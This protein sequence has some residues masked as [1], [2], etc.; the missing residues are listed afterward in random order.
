MLTPTSLKT[1]STGK[2]SRMEIKMGR[3][4]LF[5]AIMAIFSIFTLL[6]TSGVVAAWVYGTPV[7]PY[8]SQMT[9]SLGS[10]DH[11]KLYVLNISDPYSSS[12]YSSADMEKVSDLNVS[13]DATLNSA[14]SSSVSF[15]VTI[16]N[17]SDLTYYY[18]ETETVSADNNNI[19][20]TVSGIEQKD[21]IGPEESK[22]VTVTFTFK[23]GASTNDPSISAEL[24]FNFV[25]DKDSIG[26][27]VA[28]TAV[29]RFREILNNVVAA[30]S[31]ETLENAMNNR[32]GWDKE[33]AVT[34]I[35]NVYGSG[36]T[37]STAVKNLFGNEFMMMDLDGDGKPEEITMM[38]KRENLDGNNATGDSYTYRDGRN[39]VTVSGVEMT[40]YITSVKFEEENISRG[41]DIVVYVATFTKLPGAT[42]WIELVPLTSGMAP[43]NSYTYGDNWGDAD[44]FNTN[45]WESDS[46][47]TL[48]ELVIAAIS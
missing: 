7:E 31:Y 32:S 29:D 35:G 14:S 40:V 10:F 6:T 22:T 12:G 25:L 46:G 4:S 44:S 47:D 37:D 39:N 23:N 26:I 16:Y 3:R 43:A 38:I 1:P 18:N 41:E 24:H 13:V 9:V 45:K 34:Y 42:E 20:Y 30:N 28:R 15:D 19:A 48:T 21:S 33:S 17:G 2:G 11:N 5:L 27:V 36:S 8:E